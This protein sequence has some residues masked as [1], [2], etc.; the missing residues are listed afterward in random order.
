MPYPIDALS[1]IFYHACMI[2]FALA[3]FALIITPGPGV[4]SVAGVGSAFGF[5][6]GARYIGGLFV[7]NNLVAL[8][9]VSG[10]AAII[11][12]NENIRVVL[13]VASVGYLTYLAYR[14]AFAG[15]RIG[16]SEANKAPGFWSGLIL[17]PVNPKAYAVNTAFF[18][19]FP[20]WPQSLFV[21]TALKI[22]ILNMIWLPIHFIWLYAGMALHR[23]DLDPRVQ[24]RINFAMAASLLAAVALAFFAQ[25]LTE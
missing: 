14:I 15:S 13:M 18:T 1:P 11:Q 3:V 10:M 4:L 22:V 25:S 20:F 8:A 9:V 21:E 7:G 23:L 19:G 17:Q 6:P 2:T 12:A 24:R 5:A 16:F